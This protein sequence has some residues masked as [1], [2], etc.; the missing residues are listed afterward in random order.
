MPLLL[1]LPIDNTTPNA[2]PEAMET[3]FTLTGVHRRLTS[4][5]WLLEKYGK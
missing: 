1:S 3:D 4:V 5:D 2:K